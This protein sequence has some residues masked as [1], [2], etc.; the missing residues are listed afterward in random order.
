MI[1]LQVF[2]SVYAYDYDGYQDRVTQ[3]NA[4]VGWATDRV[5]NAD[6]ITNTGFED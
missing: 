5:T 2:A 4:D 1:P 6:G 3:L